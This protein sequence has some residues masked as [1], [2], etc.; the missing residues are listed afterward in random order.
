MAQNSAYSPFAYSGLEVVPQDHHL[1][2]VRPSEQDKYSIYT[3][4]SQH[5]KFYADAPEVS[6]LTPQTPQNA[7]PSRRKW[8]IIG[9]IIAILVIIGAV[10]GGVLGSRA[11]QSSSQQAASSN[12][13]VGSE[14]SGSGTG[15]GTTTG[16]SSGTASASA[17]PTPTPKSIRQ[18]S[19]LSVASWRGQ[20]DAELFL[21]FQDPQGNLRRSRYDG[22]KS[23]SQW[24]TPVQFSSSADNTTRLAGT[25][26]LF[27]T[28]QNPQTELFYSTG[29]SVLGVS[30]NDA[31]TPA[32][33]PDSVNSRKLVPGV[34]SS[35]AAYWPWL[36]Y[37]DGDGDL[38]QVRNL[39]FSSYSPSSS[40]DVGKLGVFALTASRLAVAPLSTNITKSSWKGG[41]AIFY[42][43]KDNK[44]HVNVPEINSS[45]IP[46]PYARSLPSSK[47]ISLVLGG[48]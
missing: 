10:L 31:T 40:W 23:S 45:E 3:P 6:E 19:S 13:E 30:I 35:V 16:S 38:V 5:Q 43:G 11:A 32:F 27:G 12:A 9:G 18:G 20:G 46:Q 17:T 44:I 22:S 36:I 24:E 39:L 15:T 48:K 26:F 4:Y 28:S 1:P 42:Q 14:G 21:F 2:E 29:S 25:L 41:Y 37:Q 33:Q 8:F 47:S 7:P 34:N